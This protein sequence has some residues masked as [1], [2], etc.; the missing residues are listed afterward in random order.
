MIMLVPINS[1]PVHRCDRDSRAESD[2]LKSTVFPELPGI[3]DPLPSTKTVCDD[4]VI[5]L[6]LS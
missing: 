5:M 3:D 1:V 4:I 6:F 2:Q